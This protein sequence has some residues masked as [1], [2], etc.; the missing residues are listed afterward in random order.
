MT[1]RDPNSKPGREPMDDVSRAFAA[2]TAGELKEVAEGIHL[3][4]GFGNC[5]FI[6]GE[7]GAVVV[8]P[9]LFQ[10]GPRVVSALRSLTDLPVRY[11]IYTHG[12]YD[13]AFGTPAIMEEAAERG[14]APPTVVG[15]VNLA[16]RFERYQKT[17]GHLAETY[18]MQFASWAKGGVLGG[19][20]GGEVVRKAIYVPP[21]LEYEDGIVLGLGSLALHCR[22]GLGETDDHTWVWVPERRVI[23]GGDFIVSSIPNAGAPF[24][25]QRYV[26]EWAETLEEMAGLE[27]AA[28]VSGHGGIFRDDK[29]MDMLKIT[30]EAL[31]YLEDEVVRRLNRGQWYEEILQSVEL[32]E[33]FARSPFLQPVYGCTAFAVHSILRRYTGWYDGNP[34]HL[35]PSSSA[36]IARE[37]LGL[38]AGGAGAVIE[39]ARALAAQ[40]GRDAIQRALHLLDFAIQGGA[41]EAEEARALKAEYLE[42]RAEHEESFIAR[43]VLK[44][45]AVL[46]RG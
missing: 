23:V 45:A 26:L 1:P 8:D 19:G 4:P 17:A 31:R 27:P 32:P 42:A 36:E 2:T 10:N 46:E 39:R 13:H 5:V 40:G 12:H 3:L 35:F 28:V 25:V 15:H 11:V 33:R 30:S 34:A 14:F 29:A 9:G 22:H 20:D 41:A 43:N 24:R 7:T 44:S 18:T 37:V 38:T 16:R 21:T 6:T